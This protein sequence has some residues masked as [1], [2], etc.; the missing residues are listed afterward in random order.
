MRDIGV[1]HFVQAIRQMIA[2]PRGPLD[3]ETVVIGP[4]QN[5]CHSVVAFTPT[6]SLKHLKHIAFVSTMGD[7]KNCGRAP[8]STS[9]RKESR[10][11]QVWPSGRRC[12]RASPL[13]NSAALMFRFA[14]TTTRSA[15]IR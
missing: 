10:F 12:I 3:V 11:P 2:R 5:S 14:P 8:R 1:D 9:R 7:Q 15:G 6:K 13:C 4:P